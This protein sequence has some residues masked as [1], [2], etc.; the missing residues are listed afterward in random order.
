MSSAGSAGKRVVLGVSGGIAAYKA[1]E[2]LRRL[3]ALGHDVTVVPTTAALTFV[4]AATFEALSGNPVATD[5][6]TDVPAVRH[7][8]TGLQADLVMVAPASADLLARAAAGMAD[9]LLTATLLVTRAPVLMA[10]AMHTEMWTHPATVANVATLRSRGVTVIPPAVGRLT[11]ADSGAGRLPDPEHLAQLAELTLHAAAVG[12]DALPLDLVG[13]HLVVT[14]GGTREPLDPVRF[15]GNRSSGRQGY[16]IA[17]VAAA[18]GAAVT[19]IAAN[20]ALADPPGVQLHRVTTAAELQAA[21]VQVI[22]SADAVVMAAAVA[23]FRPARP[24]AHKIKKAAGRVPPVIELMQNP[25]ILAGLVADRGD[26]RRPVIV[27]FAAE[28]GDDQ[29]SPLE[30]GR[31]K[32]ASKGCDLL[33]V[34]RVDEGRGFETDDNAAVI[35]AAGGGRTKMPF[36]PKTVLAAAV[37]DAVVTAMDASARS[38]R[39]PSADSLNTPK[40]HVSTEDTQGAST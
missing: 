39:A 14:A 38:V 5:V 40:S 29:T 1:C 27:G 6:F 31:Q 35:L 8:A 7:V 22:K 28:T 2:L 24:A 20:T 37:C 13:R 32:L 33:V 17:M 36:G 12:R 16:A 11:G 4:G 10:P 34:N 15:L 30:F 9:D 18:R 23:D 25:D 19:L 3:R 21:V 26:A